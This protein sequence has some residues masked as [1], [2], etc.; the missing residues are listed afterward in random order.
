[1]NNPKVLNA[2]CMYDWANS[3]YTLTI[4]TAVFP[5]Y[6]SAV[7][8]QPDGSDYIPFLW[9]TKRSAVVYT[10]SLSLAF[11]CISFLSPLL[12][13]IADYSG[14]KKRFMKFFVYLGSFSCMA[15]FF[16]DKEHISLGI[17][18]FSNYSD[19]KPIYY[20]AYVYSI[21]KFTK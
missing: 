13:G 2:W 3:V 12:S 6:F 20:F 17:I 19:T 15:L 11:L 10:Y 21:N 4:A 5:I 16:F 14:A 8:T 7:T 18:C 9:M 1:M